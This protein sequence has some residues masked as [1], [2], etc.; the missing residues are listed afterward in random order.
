MVDLDRATYDQEG[1]KSLLECR[2]R[3]LDKKFSDGLSRSETVLLT[4]VRWALDRVEADGY[5]KDH[6]PRP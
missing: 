5:W 1:V 3:L 6:D 4:R 2:S